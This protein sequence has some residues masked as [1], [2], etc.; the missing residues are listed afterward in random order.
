MRIA[1]F[2][3]GIADFGLSSE[4]RS[5]CIHQGGLRIAD[6]R[7]KRDPDVFIGADLGF[8]TSECGFRS[9]EW[10]GVGGYW[11]FVSGE[12]LERRVVIHRPRFAVTRK[13]EEAGEHAP[14]SSRF[15][16]AVRDHLLLFHNHHLPRRA[17]APCLDRVGVDPR[18][19]LFERNAKAVRAG[20][21]H[22]LVIPGPFRPGSVVEPDGYA[23]RQTEAIGNHGFLACRVRL[24]LFESEARNTRGALRDPGDGSR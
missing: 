14:T 16:Y 20:L 8:G 5:R 13:R 1:D 3:F 22:S 21:L 7:A 2:G 11:L 4:A 15:H 17:V 24:A 23:G 19:K 6:F 18:W 9:P 12:W 10:E